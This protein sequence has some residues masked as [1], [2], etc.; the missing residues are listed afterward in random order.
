[1][2]IP[3][4]VLSLPSLGEDVQLG[5]LYDARTGQFFGGA[6]FWSNEVVNTKQEIA[7]K[8]QNAEYSYTETLDEARKSIGLNIE[9]AIALDL[10]IIKA[11]GSAKYLN[12]TKSTSHEA[13]VD[14]SCTVIRRTRRIP[15]ET[16]ATM[17][18]E[19]RLNDDRFT[20]FVGEVVEGGTATLSFIQS[21]FSEE[22]VKKVQGSLRMA[23][24]CLPIAEVGG[25]Y[26][27]LDNVSHESV[28]VTYSGALIE[29]VT[30][31]E[32]ACRV[33][34]EMP[35][36]LG[37]Q[38]NSLSFKLYPL[39]ILDGSARH[40]IR[41][42]DD[43]LVNDVG[44]AIKYGRDT[45]LRLK[46]L[47]EL[48]VFKKTFPI[49]KDQI[50]NMEIVF[51][52]VMTNLESI[53]RRLLP[54]LRNGVTDY[55]AS[56]NEIRSAL[57]L[58]HQRLEI[59]H[60]FIRKK[61]TEAGVLAET[62]SLLLTKGF[63]NNLGAAK[64]QSMVVND[65]TRLLLS[66]SGKATSQA[67]HPLE[68]KVQASDL[69]DLS[70][71]ISDDEDEDEDDDEWFESQQSVA[72]IRES[73]NVLLEQKSR[74]NTNVTFGVT[75]VEKAYRP[76]KTKRVKTSLG[77]ILLE[78]E[79]KLLIVTGMIPKKP[80]A[81][82]L[83]VIE[84]S[85]KVDWFKE[86]SEE[87]EQ[88]IPTTGFKITFRPKPNHEK[89]S[90]LSSLTANESTQYINCG[91]DETL[92]RIDKTNLGT[93]LRDDCDYEITL[94]L[95]TMVGASVCSDRVTERT[96][97]LPSVADRMIRYH[98]ANR[99]ILSR[100]PM[101][102]VSW[103]FCDD[104]GTPTLYLGL[105]VIA[106]RM[107]SD[108]RFK[109]EVAVRI[110]DVATEFD[111]ETPAADIQDTERTVVAVFTGSSGH[112][113]TTQINAFISFLLGGK[114]SDSARVMVVDDRLADQ[115]GSVTQFVTCY[116]IRPFSPLFEGKTLLIV[117]TP[118]FGDS[119]GWQRD[120]FTT[121]AMS[122]FFRTVSHVNGIFFTCRANEA[123]TTFLSPISTYVF[124]LFAKNVAHCL[125]TVYT[126]S[127]AGAPLAREAL[128]RLHW[129]VGELREVEANNA[130]F[131]ATLDVENQVKVRDWWVMSVKAQNRL[132][133]MILKMGPKP[134]DSS[135][136]L[137]RKRITLEQRCEL[138]ERKILQ[139]ADDA[140][141]LIAKL[142]SLAEAVGKAPNEKILVMEKKVFNRDVAEGSY[143][144]LCTTC[145]RTCH[146]VCYIADDLC[147]ARCAAMSDGKCTVCKGR[148]RWQD[149]KNATFI[150][151]VKDVE[152]YV[153]PDELIQEWNSANNTL[154]GA[155]LG[156][157]DEYME[158]QEEL[159]LD[160]TYLAGLTDEIKK[161]AIMHDPEALINYLES[162]IRTSKARGAPAE[163]LVQLTTAK[164]TLI[165]VREVKD[166]GTSAT[167]ESRVLIDVLGAV[168][169]EMSKRMV[170]TA[171]IRRQ[172]ESKLCTM[173]NNLLETLPQEIRE[174]APP[175]LEKQS[176]LKWSHGA[177]Y[178]ENLKA[179]IKL[180][181]V[182]LRDGGV[183]AAI[184][185]QS[186][187]LN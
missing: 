176:W 39:D 81:P 86:R 143:T 124:S 103:K 58:F 89:D 154:E 128:R 180:V 130:W 74:C 56:F 51:R 61:R 70:S 170:M 151:D 78:K 5:M 123:R 122:D 140:R 76:G 4:N 59:V 129:P 57:T 22:E 155:L 28:K 83:T 172:E 111:K 171:S 20:H 96:E 32:D 110:V 114:P 102:H 23:L 38:L 136:T 75:S 68:K 174:K 141:S 187:N 69:R 105:T 152:N 147:K 156:A 119:R 35:A 162:L 173:Y 169:K 108:P 60:Q 45:M 146:E 179:V 104:R 118:G 93:K 135:A 63:E 87:Q 37:E 48:D 177:L 167:T 80:T 106:T 115:S 120:A 164:N 98:Q 41:A 65:T 91:P 33:A 12:D 178:P 125:R 2:L 100:A 73:C 182:V 64:P 181:K 158:L 43:S 34:G 117:D 97:A 62:I 67:Y 131:T 113:K 25:D 127:D 53:A 148:C 1:M 88:A 72:N 44:A 19:G 79:G 71:Q 30:S 109:K 16:L 159:R 36:K 134:T 101:P 163:Q 92:T 8:V 29:Q 121:A 150:I 18:F 112:G 133:E 82:S 185:A 55:D 15:Q 186:V 10:G 11:V 90:P 168:R 149:H 126:F 24:K 160:I 142:D 139:T 85:I 165:L 94:T 54:R 7:D 95:E 26:S 40:H 137:S 84:Q 138:V 77:D 184:A 6:S 9:G 66:W 46:E 99:Y 153:V 3:S 31:I 144:T 17:Q 49:I 27:K 183:V 175:P 116:R 161:T 132:K 107:C 47:Q 21:C 52:S 14:V 157:M 13:R 166:R 50:F 145:N 42:L